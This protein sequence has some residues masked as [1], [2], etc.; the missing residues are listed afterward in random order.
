M[1]LAFSAI[2]YLIYFIAEGDVSMD[3]PTIL[4]SLHHHLDVEASTGV[5]LEAIAQWGFRD[6]HTQLLQELGAWVDAAPITQDSPEQKLERVLEVEHD[7]LMDAG[8]TAVAIQHLPF[9]YSVLGEVFEDYGDAFRKVLR[10][11][12]QHVERVLE[13][14]LQKHMD[15]TGGNRFEAVP[16]MESAALERLE[17]RR[18]RV[19]AM[20][21]AHLWM[22]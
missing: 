13:D 4:Q 1:H 7:I 8:I 12:A 5:Y 2:V 10:R 18:E 3:R 21:K 6:A 16:Y 9:L 17:E 14:A 22:V 15:E 11:E 20:L 19:L